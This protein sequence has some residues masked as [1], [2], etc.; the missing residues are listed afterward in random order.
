MEF[1]TSLLSFFMAAFA[2]TT[3]WLPVS[4]QVNGARLGTRTKDR[5]QIEAAGIRIIDGTHVTL[6]T[7]VPDTW[8]CS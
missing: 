2:I 3:S 5:Q 8:V 4:A 1:K 6:F 7:D